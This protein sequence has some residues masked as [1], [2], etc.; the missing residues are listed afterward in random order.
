MGLGAAGLGS[1]LFVLRPM[2][3]LKA[4]ADRIA[5]GDLSARTQ[6]A[7]SVV[8]VTELGDA[9]NAMANALA[10][11]EQERDHAEGK[12]RD[13]EDRYRLLFAQNPHP[14]WVYDA[15][16]L[17]F[18]EVNDAA[19]QRYG[20]T[21]SEF[22]AMRIT[23]IRLPAEVPR[24]PVSVGS[25]REAVMHSSDWRHRLKSGAII[26]VEITSHTLVF[27]GR[28]AVVVTAQDITLRNRA[29]AALAERAALTTVSAEVGAALNRLGDLRGGMQGCAEAI[30]AHLD[31]AT[32]EISLID[33]TTGAVEV[34]ACAGDCLDPTTCET[35][36]AREWPLEFGHRSVGTMVIFARTRFTEGTIAG[37]TSIAAMIALGVTRHQAEDARRLLAAMVGSS[38][39]AIYGT[40]RDGTVVTWNAGAE[41]LFGYTS[42]DIVGR[43]VELLYPPDRVD[44]L[45]GLM[46]RINRGEHVRHLKRSV[47][48]RT[49][50]WCRWR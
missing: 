21:R 31:F 27:A 1:H 14:M 34:A 36:A 28:P 40:A 10:T 41:R 46:A 18:L 32:V 29:E 20:Y 35:L 7:G 50:R 45:P 2:K 38:D 39:E 44:E 48:A 23:D 26:D 42:A 4:V 33:P 22:L 25:P 47:S 24:L 30:V 15:E 43:P 9:V 37:L 3:S 17:E 49:D 11:R 5:A 19:V 16:T 12:L 13:S 6:L 8:G